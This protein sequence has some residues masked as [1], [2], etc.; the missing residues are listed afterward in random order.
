MKLFLFLT[1]LLAISGAQPPDITEYF[2]IQ[3]TNVSF[4][5]HGFN[6][7]QVIDSKL[8]W[9]EVSNECP[10]ASLPSGI[11]YEYPNRQNVSLGEILQL[12]S[13]SSRN[14]IIKSDPGAP[15]NITMILDTEINGLMMKIP[16]SL[17]VDETTNSPPCTYV[18]VIPCS[19][20]HTYTIPDSRRFDFN[21]QTYQLDFIHPGTVEIITQEMCSPEGVDPTGFQGEPEHLPAIIFCVTCC[22]V[23]V[24][25]ENKAQMYIPWTVN[26]QR[27]PAD[28]NPNNPIGD[29]SWFKLDGTK[30]K[31]IFSNLEIKN[32]SVN[33]YHWPPHLILP[34]YYTVRYNSQVCSSCDVHLV[35]RY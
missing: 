21:G 2:D 26:L 8:Y 1:I 32:R 20:L 27:I 28:N 4:D 29:L 13:I 9:G 18:S 7:C 10:N 22:P 17:E 24:W 23:Y 11:K 15:D 34:D 33:T 6:P 35:V 30:I 14:I 5:C 19:D 25:C 12:G 3:V 31:T 16:I